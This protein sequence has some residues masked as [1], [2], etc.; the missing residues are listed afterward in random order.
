MID[1]SRVQDEPKARHYG[2]DPNL[3]AYLR[4]WSDWLVCRPM[5][6]LPSAPNSGGIFALG[7]W[8]ELRGTL[9]YLVMPFYYGEAQNLASVTVPQVD[10]EPVLRAYAVIEDEEQRR[11][12]LAALRKTSERER[13]LNPR[14]LS[15]HSMPRFACRGRSPVARLVSQDAM[16][17]CSSVRKDRLLF[18][19]I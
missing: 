4:N 9:S 19:I 10:C 3:A 6:N 8:A 11:I 15:A 7:I 5:S 18:A 12:L 2:I 17:C 1:L 16:R 14:S 13:G